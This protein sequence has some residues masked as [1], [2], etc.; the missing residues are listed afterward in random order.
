MN[1]EKRLKETRIACKIADWFSVEQHV[2]YDFDISMGVLFAEGRIVFYNGDILEFTESI[3]PDRFRYRYH[4]MTAGRGLIFR[5]DNVPHH[6]EILTFPDHKH[7][8]DKIVES[9][10]VNLKEIV[11][12][13]IEVIVG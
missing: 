1:I 11:E 6:S 5:Y 2:D 7:F 12:E 13:I 10:P 8:P 3:T 9:S 4:Y